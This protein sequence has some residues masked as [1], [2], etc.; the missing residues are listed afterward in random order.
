VRVP[1]L[2]RAQPIFTQVQEWRSHTLVIWTAEQLDT[3]AVN[4]RALQ[5]PSPLLHHIPFAFYSSALLQSSQVQQPP[6]GRTPR[7]LPQ[8]RRLRSAP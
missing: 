2:S 3:T 8:T 4:L 1:V 6:C 7:P 5:T